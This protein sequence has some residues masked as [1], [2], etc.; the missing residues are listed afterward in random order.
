MN[1]VLQIHL[2]HNQADRKHNDSIR[3]LFACISFPLYESM[4]AVKK[5]FRF[6][7]AHCKRFIIEGDVLLQ[8][9]AYGQSL[10]A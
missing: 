3:A 2:I 1:S 4:L 7:I 5:E 8:A 6:G 9:A 10:Q